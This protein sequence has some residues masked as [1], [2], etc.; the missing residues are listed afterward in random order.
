MSD[1]KPDA[2]K[3]T[4]AQLRELA[5]R[6]E[7]DAKRQRASA[8]AQEERA[9]QLRGA[10]DTI[11]AIRA[12]GPLT[13]VSINDMRLDTMSMADTPK[14]SGPKF[15]S[16]HPLPIRAKALGKSIPDVAAELTKALKRNV[17]RTTVR[18]WYLPKGDESARPIPADAVK[19]FEADPWG[20]SRDAWKNGIKDPD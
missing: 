8:A 4:P 12:M 18:S 20:I 6:L 2:P 11:E 13:T 9:R 14:V 1:Q 7:A 19:F 16:R 5:D 15:T 3:M 10:A 17:P